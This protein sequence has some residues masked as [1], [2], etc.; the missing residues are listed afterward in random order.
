VE[1]G[2]PGHWVVRG[3]DLAPAG[4]WELAVSARV[5]EFDAYSA[6]LE[7]PIE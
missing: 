1:K 3:G 7:V 5:S 4:D 6:E 2:G